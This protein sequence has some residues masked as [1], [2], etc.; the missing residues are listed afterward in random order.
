MVLK[1]K[2]KLLILI[3]YKFI[4]LK[5]L[6]ITL[7]KFKKIINLNKLLCIYF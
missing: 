5:Q 1:K 6:V 2:K 4:Q 3:F 7:K